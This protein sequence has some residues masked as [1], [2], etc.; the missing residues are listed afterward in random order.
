MARDD[1]GRQFS[2]DVIF[3]NLMTMLLAGEDTTAYTLGWAVHQLCDSPE[4]VMEL[5][6]EADELFGTSDMAGDIETANKLAW[7]GAVAN[8]TM[9]LRPVAAFLILEAKVETVV[10]DLLVPAGTHVC[11]LT[12]PAACDPGRFVEPQAFRPRRWL[13]ETAGAHDVS[14]H[15]PFGSGPRICPGRVLALLE[16]KLLLS[17]LY[18]NFDVERVGGAEGVWENFA[19]AM[20]PVGLKVRLRRRSSALAGTGPPE[21]PSRTRPFLTQRA[22]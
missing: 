18:R 10:G 11:V 20:L 12:R 2:D 9:R 4:L 1:E 7:A 21:S 8:E 14:A 22:S 16:M 5:R 13:G 15:I 6:R 17:M 19:F 3:G